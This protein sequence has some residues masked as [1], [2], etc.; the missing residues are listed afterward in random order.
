[1]IDILSTCLLYAPAVSR[2]EPDPVRPQ[3]RVAD[4]LRA[5][6]RHAPA[7]A[8]AG[9][10]PGYGPGPSRLGTRAAETAAALPARAGGQ[11]RRRA[12]RPAGRLVH[13]RRHGRRYRRGARRRRHPPGP[14][15]GGEPG[16]HGGPGTCDQP[17]GT[18]RRPR[19][20][21]HHA[22][23]ALLLPDARRLD[24]ADRGDRPH[25]GRGGAAP[26]HGKRPVGGHRPGPSGTRDTASSSS[27]APGQRTPT[28]CQP[29]RP[30]E[31]GTPAA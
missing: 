22:G 11:P 2:D 12:Q 7:A 19:P 15:D 13:R 31:H 10:H 16:R 1:M 18:R 14:R 5:A 20:G 9:P 27:R 28:C 29:R 4:R 25:D 8:V 24:A 21:V 3:R 6:R 30:R 26:P 23:L 17:P